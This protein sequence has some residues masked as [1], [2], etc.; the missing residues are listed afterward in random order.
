[1]VVNPKKLVFLRHV[2]YDKDTKEITSKGRE[3]AKSIGKKLNEKLPGANKGNT[4]VLVSG[5]TR[6][7]Q[8]AG[9]MLLGIQGEVAVSHD[10]A[11][12]ADHDTAANSNAALEVVQRAVI[13]RNMENIIIISH[14]E[15]YPT[16]P[17][18]ILSWLKKEGVEI[19]DM[20]TFFPDEIEKGEGVFLDFEKKEVKVISP[21]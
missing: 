11:F 16:L 15:L 21:T 2:D 8:T 4:L 1:M 19:G 18:A 14:A 3:D 6:A 7:K 9:Y 12:T 13:D 5:A 20:R 10:A 17:F